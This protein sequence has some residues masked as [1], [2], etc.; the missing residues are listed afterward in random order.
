MEIFPHFNVGEYNTKQLAGFHFYRY[1]KQWCILVT[2]FLDWVTVV[3]SNSKVP[4]VVRLVDTKFRI[5]VIGLEE[6][7]S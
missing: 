3:I 6:K 1:I 5:G 2:G 7:K 4:S